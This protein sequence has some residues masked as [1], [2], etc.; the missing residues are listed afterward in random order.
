MRAGSGVAVAEC[1]T[2]AVTA[3]D[4]PLIHEP[5]LPPAAP[6]AE[7]PPRPANHTA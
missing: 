2:S 5:V 4:Q 3:A 7:A 1:G 6:A